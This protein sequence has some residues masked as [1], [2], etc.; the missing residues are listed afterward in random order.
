MTTAE[1][2][3]NFEG[4][5]LGNGGTE[6]W[7]WYGLGAGTAWC[8]AFQS[9]ALTECGI[10]TRYAWVSSLFD[11]YRGRGA[12]SYDIRNAKPGDLVAFEWGSTPNGYDHIAMIL[13]RTESGCWTRNGNVNGSK[14]ADLWFPFDGGGMA[15][16][17]F[18]AYETVNPSTEEND[19]MKSI[20]L[21]DR[22]QNPAP[23]YHAFGNTKVWLNKQEQ[24]DLL[25]FFGC[26]VIDPAPVEWLDAL[27]T[28][29]KG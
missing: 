19:E 18:P 16:L 3:L 23:V 2:V 11:D 17:A 21:V 24:V 20:L 8:C 22:R 14:V 15:E 9:M 25:K 5:R 1:Q 4:A 27:A 10:P 6:T 29:P 7:D 28:I 12:T 26:Q 13:S